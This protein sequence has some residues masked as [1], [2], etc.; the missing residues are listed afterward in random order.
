MF[1][2]TVHPLDLVLAVCVAVLPGATIFYWLAVHGR[3]PFDMLTGL[4][5]LVVAAAVMLAVI[6]GLIAFAVWFFSPRR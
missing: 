1:R 4:S 2:K 5:Y 3:L 6:G